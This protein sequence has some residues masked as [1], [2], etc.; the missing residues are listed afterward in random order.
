MN[1]LGVILLKLINEC[2]I[3]FIQKSKITLIMT[4]MSFLA[5]SAKFRF[6][7]LA[8]F[9]CKGIHIYITQLYIQNITY[10]TK[11]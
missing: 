9:Y 7:T 5:S 3:M 11:Q 2:I 4:S 10:F 8:W 1:I 6:A